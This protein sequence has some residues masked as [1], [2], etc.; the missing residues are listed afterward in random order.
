[1][2]DVRKLYILTITV[3]RTFI[4]FQHETRFTF[5]PGNFIFVFCKILPFC[6]TYFVQ[7]KYTSIQNIDDVKIID[8]KHVVRFKLI[9]ILCIRSTA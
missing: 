3:G 6:N 5:L 2:Y 4:W 8:D 7:Y 1:M 9:S